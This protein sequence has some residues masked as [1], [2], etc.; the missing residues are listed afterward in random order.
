MLGENAERGHRGSAPRFAL[1]RNRARR[2]TLG[3]AVS[4]SRD[5]V[6]ALA[7]QPTPDDA[8]APTHDCSEPTSHG[9]ATGDARH[10]RPLAPA[11]RMR[12][13]VAGSIRMRAQGRIHMWAP[14]HKRKAPAASSTDVRRKSMPGATSLR[15]RKSAASRPGKFCS[16]SCSSS[17]NPSR[18]RRSIKDASEE[19][20]RIAWFRESRASGYPK[21]S[22]R[23][24]KKYTPQ[25][26]LTVNASTAG[27]S[28][29]LQPGRL[30][31]VW[32]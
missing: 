31:V 21:F 26:I 22:G 14:A 25:K 4:D 30:F 17:S 20:P 8:V 16:S 7:R 27:P 2:Q 19:G 23:Y 5:R 10:S 24:T 1:Y 15:P 12:M 6:L 3:M 13:P 28:A 18:Q 29:V 9:H 11:A 32:A